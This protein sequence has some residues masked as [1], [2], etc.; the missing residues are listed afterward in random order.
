MSSQVEKYWAILSREALCIATF[1]LS[2][3]PAKSQIK[4]LLK[5]SPLDRKNRFVVY[6]VIRKVVTVKSV[7]CLFGVCVRSIGAYTLE[8]ICVST[9]PLWKNQAV[10][11][12][13]IALYKYLVRIRWRSVSRK[14]KIH[15][16]GCVTFS[17]SRHVSGLY[18]ASVFRAEVRDTRRMSHP[19][20]GVYCLV[21]MRQ[22]ASPTVVRMQGMIQSRDFSSPVSPRGLILSPT[23]NTSRMLSVPELISVGH[24]RQ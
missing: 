6:L 1:Q 9:F 18:I 20:C 8:T 5:Q 2:T 10:N 16:S 12:A 11:G 13:G 14:Q 21:A 17:I 23:G 22:R 24:R 19:P 4:I 3:Y 15:A 7:L